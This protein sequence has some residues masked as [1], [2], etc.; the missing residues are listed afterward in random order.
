V[1]IDNFNANPIDPLS[2]CKQ[3]GVTFDRFR[4]WQRRFQSSGFVELTP[5][6]VTE[7]ATAFA[8]DPS[9]EVRRWDIELCLGSDIILRLRKV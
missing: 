9:T 3:T 6:P 2:Y 1:L 4:I 8:V 7:V 5:T